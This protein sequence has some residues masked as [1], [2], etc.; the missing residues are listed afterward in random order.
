[1]IDSIFHSINEKSEINSGNYLSYV[2][3]KDE[4]IVL[5]KYK[6]KHCG[7]IVERE[8]NKQWIHSYCDSTGKIVHLIKI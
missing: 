5:N 6:C 8:S 4:D 7:A 3:D 2:V 1:M